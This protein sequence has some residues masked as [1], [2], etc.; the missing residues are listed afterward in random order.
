L[1]SGTPGRR[2]MWSRDRQDH[3]RRFVPGGRTEATMISDR[4]I[5]VFP[6][7]AETRPR[8]RGGLLRKYEYLRSVS[9]RHI[10]AGKA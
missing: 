2:P 1:G 10:Y 5:E 6:V 8:R 3:G 7:R 9:G 4:R